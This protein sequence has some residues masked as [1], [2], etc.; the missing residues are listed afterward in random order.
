MKPLV[1]RLAVLGLGLL[2]GSVAL[3]AKSRGTA[4]RVV[5]AGRRRHALE[6]ARARGVVDEVAD[7]ETAVRGADLVVLAT[8]VHAMPEILR[9]V[10]PQLAQGAVVTDVGSVKAPLADTLPGLLPQGVAYVGSHPLAGSHLRGVEHA[11]SD[12]LEG[13][14]CAV[15]P[16]AAVDRASVERVAEFW[17]R[18]GAR[19][20]QRDPADHDAEVSWTSHV[21]HVLA[22]AFA[23]A[24]ASAP[25]GTR[26][27]QG[28]GF[29][30]FTRI[31]QS[32][33]ELWSDI[34]TANRK[35]IAGPLQTVASAVGSLA[36]AI[37]ANDAEAVEEWVAAAREALG[38]MGAAATGRTTPDPGAKTRKSR[39]TRL[40]EDPERKS[41]KTHE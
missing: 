25:S 40:R 29:R 19:V 4:A 38:R 33:S 37:E 13:A 6:A 17:R 41:K 8:P 15:T 7:F 2:G 5:G 20:V 30:D 34:L 23:R 21:P 18:L 32:D 24:L 22:F 39:S 10:A 28:P 14:P 36:A 1:D 27:L 3:A 16:T 11:R 26:E 31:G 12:L 9:R 35:A